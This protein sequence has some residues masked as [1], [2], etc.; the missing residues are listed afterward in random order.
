MVEAVLPWITAWQVSIHRIA[1]IKNRIPFWLESGVICLLV[2][3]LQESNHY[4]SVMST[5]P[6]LRP[7]IILQI[8][9]W[10]SC[11]T[12]IDCTPMQKRCQHLFCTTAVIDIYQ[13]ILYYLLVT[14]DSDGRK[15]LDNV[16]EVQ[17]LQIRFC[18]LSTMKDL[19]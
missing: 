14:K 2:T 13:Q 18:F 1:A 11:I 10:I 15:C 9:L 16:A 8:V 5:K 6:Y 3:V 12:S 4:L 17:K 19:W 7:G